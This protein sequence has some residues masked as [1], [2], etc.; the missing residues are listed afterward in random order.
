MYIRGKL[1]VDFGK[2][3]AKPRMLERDIAIATM[4]CNKLKVLR[5]N[6]WRILPN[7]I[8]Y[9]HLCILALKFE[10]TNGYAMGINIFE[11]SEEGSMPQPKLL[12]FLRLDLI[13]LVGMQIID[14]LV[15]I[16][17]KVSF[18]SKD[19]LINIPS[20]NLSLQFSF[21]DYFKKNNLI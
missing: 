7:F 21:D 18:S 4:Y 2:S 19:Y 1:E 5:T 15:V 10:P 20:N 14:N 13:G 12:H 17:H 3:N 11:L 9:G 6:L 16:H 8:S